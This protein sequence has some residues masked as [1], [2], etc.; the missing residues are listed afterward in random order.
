M[1]PLYLHR[2]WVHVY[3]AG[4]LYSYV[5]PE[6]TNLKRASYTLH[7]STSGNVTTGGKQQNCVEAKERGNEEEG[8]AGEQG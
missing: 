8:G 4:M 7:I 5:S 2:E 6:R 3:R 1:N